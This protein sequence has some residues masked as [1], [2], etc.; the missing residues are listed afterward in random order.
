L[1]PEYR[2]GT[3][4]PLAV[5]IQVD[6]KRRAERE[7]RRKWRVALGVVLLFLAAMVGLVVASGRPRVDKVHANG[8]LLWK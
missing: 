7:R 6:R 2:R 8:G 4:I 5:L 3:V 1:R